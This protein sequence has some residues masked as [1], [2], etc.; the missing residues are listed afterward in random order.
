MQVEKFIVN[1]D[2][3][4]KKVQV[5]SESSE[6]LGV[7]STKEALDLAFSNNVDLV[8]VNDSADIAVCK[9]M[10]YKK[11]LYESKKRLRENKDK[12]SKVK[13]KEVQ[14]NVNIGEHDI[15][16]K[17][18][19]SS[20]FLDKGYKVKGMIMLKGREIERP[21]LSLALYKKFLENLVVDYKVTREPSLEGNRLIFHLE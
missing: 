11:F 12:V 7:M 16:V 21:Q 19:Q 6:N 3:K 18:D 14:M 10:D 20:K 2:I 4:F 13:W 17:A 15:K 9:L 5:I 1:E 8:L